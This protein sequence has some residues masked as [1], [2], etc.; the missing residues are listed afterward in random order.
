M[1]DGSNLPFKENIMKTKRV[2]RIMHIRGVSVE[3][4]ERWNYRRNRRGISIAGKNGI[5]KSS[6]C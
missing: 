2:V 6:R 4:E 5:H 3:G 1:F